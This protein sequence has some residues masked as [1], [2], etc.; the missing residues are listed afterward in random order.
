MTS[1]V[2]ITWREYVEH[3]LAYEKS[4]YQSSG[5][6]WF[7]YQGRD[8]WKIKVWF[9]VFDIEPK[10]NSHDMF[11]GSTLSEIFGIGQTMKIVDEPVDD[12]V[13]LRG[14]IKDIIEQ[15]IQLRR[16]ASQQ[17]ES[18]VGNLIDYNNELRGLFAQ[19]NKI[20]I[21][22]Q[23]MQLLQSIGKIKKGPRMSRKN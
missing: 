1:E 15:L 6:T 18:Q 17:E 11:I 22:L 16:E 8:G 13:Q 23:R 19:I 2:E 21:I 9:P 20:E 3:F 4:N 14:E 12:N 5:P 7:S 10:Q